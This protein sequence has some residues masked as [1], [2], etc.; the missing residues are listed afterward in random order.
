MAKPSDK[1][2]TEIDPNFELHSDKRAKEREE[3]DMGRINREAE[4]DAHRKQIEERRRHEE[5]V[6]IQRLRK[7][8]VHKAQPVRHFKSVDIKRGEKPVTVPISPQFTYVESSK[9]K[10]L[11]VEPERSQTTTCPSL[12]PLDEQPNENLDETFDL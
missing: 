8:T 4:L 11:T 6:E 2:L 9:R 1:S 5:Y 12:D 3:Y 7:E 10:D